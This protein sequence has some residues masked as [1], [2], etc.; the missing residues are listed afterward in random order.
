[1]VNSSGY[2]SLRYMSSESM[3]YTTRSRSEVLR[4]GIIAA[5]NE[6]AALLA[7]G[8]RGPGAAACLEGARTLAAELKTLSRR[9]GSTDGY[10]DA[11]RMLAIIEE[12]QAKLNPA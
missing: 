12:L 5:I 4:E 9:M 8:D 10:E 2:D 6:T 7:A 1:M 3:I 11:V